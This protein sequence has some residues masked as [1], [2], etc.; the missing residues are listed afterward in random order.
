MNNELDDFRCTGPVPG[1]H[2]VGF[3]RSPA[4]T[5]PPDMLALRQISHSLS[6]EAMPARRIE[7]LLQAAL[8]STGASWG[9]LAVLRD[10]EWDVAASAVG[11]A[12][13]RSLADPDTFLLPPAM[14]ALPAAILD[15]ATRL[16]NGLV[17]QDAREAA[18][19]QADDYVRRFRPRAVICVPMRCNGGLV[20]ALYLEHLHTSGVFT[21][22][23]T[24]VVEII[25]QQAGF[26][27]ENARLHDALSE[28]CA[29]LSSTE[30]K[31]RATLSELARAS[32]L[33]AYGELVASIVHEMAQP[34]TA[35][36]SSARAGLRWLDRSSPNIDGAREMLA[37]ISA[38]ALRARTIIN[39]LRAKARQAAPTFSLFDLDDALRE[40]ADMVAATLDAMHVE[41]RLVGPPCGTPLRGERVP[42]Q[43]AIINLLMNGAESMLGIPTGKRLLTLACE[44]A[45][46]MLHIHIDDH[47]EGF[48]P[49]LADRIFEPLFTTKPHGMGMG[50][51]ICRSIVDAHHGRLDLAQRPTGGTRATITLPRIAN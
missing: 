49:E 16:G 26:A 9:C 41:L 48:A 34:V 8:Q 3:D 12:P 21:P 32:R 13:Q 2:P 11:P 10:G 46:D 5:A 19:W 40:V 50:L 36:D 33:Q 22:T 7:T 4:E 31:M 6:T 15:A 35:L 38:C 18:D 43:Q 17:L 51:G 44:P 42:L 30:E 39:G 25:A 47:G 29:R 1:I 45:Q 23:R 24:A 14:G 28:Q 20:G 37:H 27:L